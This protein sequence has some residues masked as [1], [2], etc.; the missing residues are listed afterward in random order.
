MG[1]NS[2]LYL[3]LCTCIIFSI[4]ANLASCE[5]HDLKSAPVSSPTPKSSP[6]SNTGCSKNLL[7]LAIC[8]PLLHLPISID[9]PL[10]NP[11]CSTLLG[12]L[13]VELSLC[14]CLAIKAN[15][16][17]INVNLPVALNLLL[18]TCKIQ[19]PINFQCA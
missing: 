4:V 8:T 6:A 12:L 19:N 9:N 10:S 5:S 17:G 16:L 2:S 15:I 7:D 1:A 14:L 11:C 18:D 13:D 3:L